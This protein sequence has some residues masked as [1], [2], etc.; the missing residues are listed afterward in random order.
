[1]TAAQTHLPVLG[2]PVE[3]P[4]AQGHGLAA[5]D[6]ADARRRAGR[7]AR[8]R[9]R[10][11]RSTRRCLPPTIVALRTTKLR[12]RVVHFRATQTRTC[13][14]T[15]ILPPKAERRCASASSAAVSSAACSRWPASDLGI[16]CTT[17]DPAA[18]SP[19]AQVGPSIVGAYDDPTALAR[20]ADGADVLTYEFENVPVDG[21]A[22]LAE[23]LARVPAA[24]RARGVTGS[25]RREDALHRRRSARA[26]RS[27]RS[28]RSA[29]AARGARCRSDCPPC[30]RRAGS[31]TTARG[32]RSFAIARSP[33]TSGERSA[34][35]PRSWRRSCRSTGSFRCSRCAAATASSRC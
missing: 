13:S 27:R 6:R 25:D 8:D 20:L 2:V 9:A 32:R 4:S 26:R 11:A 23:R 19:A 14:T 31:A 15:R 1:M 28:Q 17:L 12:E 10:A 5:V 7:H 33:R 3:S 24:S 34:R 29:V 18:D 22:R 16:E 21:V 35:C 30:S